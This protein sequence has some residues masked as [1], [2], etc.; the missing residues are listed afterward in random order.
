MKLLLIF[1]VIAIASSSSF[2][3]HV[4]SIEWLPAWIGSQM[5]G[6][7]TQTSWNVRYIAAITSI[8]YG[9]AALS[10]YFLARDRLIKYGLF[11][12]SLIFSVLLTAIH[13]AFI[14]QPFMDYVV[15]NPI[16]VVLVQTDSNG[17]YGFLCHL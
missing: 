10:L 5:K 6:L 9:F 7:T 1:I 15:G 16:Q 8:E 17:L 13:G 2:V 14:R 12:A 3:V 4:I 11:K